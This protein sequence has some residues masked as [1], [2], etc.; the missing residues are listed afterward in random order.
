MKR[1]ITIVAISSIIII[2]LYGVFSLILFDT[3]AKYTDYKEL[4]HYFESKELY[5]SSENLSPQENKYNI[6]N[7][8]NFNDINLEITN[9]VNNNQITNYDINYNLECNVL[10]NEEKIYDCIIDNTESNKISDTLIS[11]KQ[12]IEDNTLTEEECLLQKYKYN[13]VKTFKNHKFKIITTNK[14]Q[15]TIKVELI[16]N[17][18]SP[19]S[20]TLK[21]IY[22]LNIGDD[23]NNNINI[24]E[25]KDYNSFCEYIISNNY[26]TNKLIKLSID[27]SKLIF[28]TTNDIYNSKIDYTTNNNIINTITFVLTEN[29]NIKVYK[30]DFNYKCNINDINYL[31]VE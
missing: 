5:I 21:A 14:E 6:I 31:I 7:Y 1:T 24:S 11:N 12:C 27:T 25:V 9:S 4:N 2:L 3:S 13:L 17:T 10:D 8:Y 29:T 22:I 18:I 28:D 23:Q 26:H 19:Y 15:T 30:K 20:K 16:L